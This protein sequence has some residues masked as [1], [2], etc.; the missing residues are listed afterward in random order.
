MW[1]VFVGAGLGAA[2]GGSYGLAVLMLICAALVW[3]VSA[4]TKGQFGE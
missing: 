2:Y 3:G 1:A 4:V